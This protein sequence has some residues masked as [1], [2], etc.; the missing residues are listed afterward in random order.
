[1]SIYEVV[2][3]RSHVHLVIEHCLGTPVFHYVKKL[4]DNR[5]SEETCKWFFRQ[6]VT[7]VSYMHSKDLAHRDLKLENILIN[8]DDRQIK[9]IDFG[10]AV[11]TK[12]DRHESYCGTPHYMDPDIVSKV[13]YSAKAAD[14]WALGVILYIVS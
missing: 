13:P 10:F 1:M 2:N 4:N 7:A 3:T 11:E 9:V 5:M 14:V 12:V 8:M 6:L